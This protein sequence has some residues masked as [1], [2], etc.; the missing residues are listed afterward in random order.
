MGALVTGGAGYIGSQMV[1]CLLQNHRQVVVVDDLSSGHRDTLPKGVPLV[2][3]NVGDKEAM[4]RLLREHSVDSIFHFAGS[5][6]P[7]SDDE[8][9]AMLA[10][11]VARE[12]AASP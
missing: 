11:L 5:I 7:V 3:A 12:R 8:A 4:T 10:P 1:R 2:V 6:L 9:V